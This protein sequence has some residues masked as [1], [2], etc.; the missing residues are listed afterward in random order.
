MQPLRER[1]RRV[2]ADAGPP[3][4]PILVPRTKSGLTAEVE[5]SVLD[6]VLRTGEAMISTGAPA[7]DVTAALLRLAAGFGVTSCQIDITFIAIIA[8]I[9]RDDDP[10]TQMR[11]INVR[12]ADYSRLDA[13]IRL[14]DDAGARRIDLA[15]AHHRL[16]AIVAA[17]HPYRRWLVTVALGVMAA[18][19]AVLLNGGW[20]TALVAAVTTMLVDRILRMLR[21]KGVPYLFQQAVGA[22]IA[23]LVALGLIWSRERFGWSDELL[24]PSLVVA[25]GIVVL[26]AGLSLVGAAEDAISGFPLTAAARGFEVVLYTVGIVVGIGFVLDL[27]QRLGVP[28]RI[29]DLSTLSTPVVLQVVAGGVIAGA[30]A[31]ASY[32]RAGTVAFVVPVGA[33]AVAAYLGFRELALGASTS[34]FAAALVVGLLAGAA[35]PRLHAPPLVVSICGITPLLPGLAIYSAMFA[36]VESGNLIEGVGDLLGAAGIGLALAAGVTLGEFLATPLG[37]EADRWKRRVRLR[38]RGSRV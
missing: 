35:G 2:V 28:L 8:S 21:N 13:L 29:T 22:G 11:V 15:E 16:D 9:D 27:G 38:A 34:T 36:L 6:L 23:T 24:P 19:V 14:V 30:W 18:G 20:L 25:S 26:L 5:R 33:V 37:A 3:T 17:P 32:T 7:G 4:V 10:I 1:A 12:T 31:I